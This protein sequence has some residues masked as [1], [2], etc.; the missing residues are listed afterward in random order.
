M[1]RQSGNVLITLLT[2]LHISHFYTIPST[3]GGILQ[4]HKCEHSYILSFCLI[5]FL[6]T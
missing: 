3:V 6:D 4:A 1:T 5:L 2:P